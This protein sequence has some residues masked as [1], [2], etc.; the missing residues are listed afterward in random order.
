[1]TGLQLALAGGA[2][3]G[4]GLALLV[5]RLIPAD[6]DLAA[7]L[8][9]LAP[10]PQR[11]PM[12]LRPRQAPGD[13]P[14]PGEPVDRV[15][16]LG[17]WAL[18]HLPAGVWTHTP[19]RQLALLQVSLSRFYGEKVVWA[20]LGLA[21][22]PVLATAF[23]LLG[24]GLPVTIPV[25]GSLALAGLFW[26]VPNYN[27]AEDAKQARAEFSRAL[28]AYIDM[29]AT[30]VRDG[31]S[32]QQALAVAAEVGDSWV[33]DRLDRE[34]RRARYLTRAP[35]DALRALAAEVGVPEVEDLADIMQQAGQDGA[36]IYTSLRARAAGLRSAMLSAEVAKANATSERMYVPASLLGVVFMAI[37]LTPALLR[38][39]S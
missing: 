37:L 10:A 18:R 16:Q 22:P 8:D 34:L 5:W 7:V 1:M 6:P 13:G 26:F 24:L 31:A 25:A 33:F 28:G 19:H 35:W 12:S 4:L 21:M 27:A 11:P 9:R 29:V 3:I 17:R 2:L 20:L 39:T 36:Q 23:T 30:A 32:G 38:L 15:D 14:G